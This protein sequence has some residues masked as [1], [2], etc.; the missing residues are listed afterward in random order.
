MTIISQFFAQNIDTIF[1]DWKERVR[2]D[3][4]IYS[5]HHLNEAAL[6]NSVPKVLN[7][8]AKTLMQKTDETFEQMASA[9]LEHGTHRFEQGFDIREI[10]REYRLLRE[11]I[12]DTLSPALLKLSVR[13][14]QY[15]FRLIDAIIDE[16]SADC[17]QR[18][19]D[20]QLADI[21]NLQRQQLLNYQELNRLLQL[22]QQNFSYL[23]HEIKN[24]LTSIMGYSQL[25][26]RQQ[27]EIEAAENLNLKHIE[28]VL[29]SSRQLLQLVNDALA[30]SRSQAN[31]EQLQLES[32]SVSALL[33]YAV[34]MVKP[35]A[36]TKGLQVK[37]TRDRALEQ[38]TTD[39]T[40]L[41]QILN[42]LLGNAAR[43]TDAGYIHIICEM[44]PRD[45][46][47][48]AISDTG[49]GIAPA[50][51][52]MVFEPFMRASSNTAVTHREGST[53]LGL[54]IVKWLVGLL[55]GE[56]ELQSAI[57][58]GS[59]FTVILPQHLT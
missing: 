18:F 51:H 42:N 4:K 40:Y 48:I 59:T 13:E 9:S 8:I 14:Q 19:V 58:K 24:P 34:A 37:V 26:L 53:G 7:A 45:R 27:Q 15:T 54:A 44:R 2:H 43:Y 38:V 28:R 50:E 3:K 32:I 33:D 52:K 29:R 56:I 46:W 22:N 23:A 39:I 47:A 49:I 6:G 1:A 55:E 35:L 30:L 20:K 21:E 10:A 5:S 25:L 16:A 31:P 41:Q 36:E 11:T 12:F 17:F 57:N